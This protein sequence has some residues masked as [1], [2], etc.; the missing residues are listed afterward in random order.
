M[1]KPASERRPFE[2]AGGDQY[3][4][5][6]CQKYTSDF[7][8]AFVTRRY[9]ACRK[10]FKRKQAHRDAAKGIPKLK[11]QLYKA[12]H[13]RGHREVA[14]GVTKE[15]VEAILKL[16]EANVNEVVRIIPPKLTA[17]ARRLEKFDV[18]LKRVFT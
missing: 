8:P 15:T 2:S 1:L 17:D 4:C 7:Y 9:R 5:N 10:C 12:L 14:R 11:R 18:V 3:W 6:D 16:H 13:G